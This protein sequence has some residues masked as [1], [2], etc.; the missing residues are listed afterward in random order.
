MQKT[1]ENQGERSK[2]VSYTYWVSKPTPEA[3]GVFAPQ[4]IDQQEAEK[5]SELCRQ[6]SQGSSWNSAG[7]WEEKAI[8]C[9][10]MKKYLKTCIENMPQKEWRLTG[11]KE[12]SGDV[13]GWSER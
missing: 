7:T 6:M 11:I 4:K 5:I 2:E 13:S 12:M 9:D 8:P 1:K 3:K 10:V